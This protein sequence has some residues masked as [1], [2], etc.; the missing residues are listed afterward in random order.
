MM[1]AVLDEIHGAST[2]PARDP[3]AA[4]ITTLMARARA[5]IALIGEGLKNRDIEEV[6]GQKLED[7]R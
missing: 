4:K 7:T 6:R 5:V 3:E 1:A 2:A